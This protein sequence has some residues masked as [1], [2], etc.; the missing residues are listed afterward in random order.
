M[1]LLSYF[2]LGRQDRFQWC[3]VIAWRGKVAT[4][5]FVALELAFLQV[6]NI[7]MNHVPL[8]LVNRLGSLILPN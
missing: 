6:I 4:D 8:G 7:E 5:M 2:P 1:T 3:I